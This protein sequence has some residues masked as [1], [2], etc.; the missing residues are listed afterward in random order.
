MF[1]RG[2]CPSHSPP[3]EVTVGRVRGKH[4]IY[5]RNW[6]LVLGEFAVTKRGFVGQIGTPYW[7]RGVKPLGTTWGLWH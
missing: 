4:L 2:V 5:I 7:H 1:N 6:G 3:G